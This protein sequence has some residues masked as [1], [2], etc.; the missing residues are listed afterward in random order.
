MEHLFVRVFGGSPKFWLTGGDL[1]NER[2]QSCDAVGFNKIASRFT[3]GG[4]ARALAGSK[5]KKKNPAK[6]AVD[7]R[8]LREVIGLCF[9][10]VFFLYLFAME[11]LYDS[12]VSTI[13]YAGV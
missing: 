1:L 12:V 5:M 6:K 2:Q 9:P 13:V 10:T 8:R 7:V 4:F 11:L 3:Q